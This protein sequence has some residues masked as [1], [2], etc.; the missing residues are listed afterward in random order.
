MISDI[1]IVNI[2]KIHPKYDL[3]GRMNKFGSHTK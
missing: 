3:M 1:G 2:T